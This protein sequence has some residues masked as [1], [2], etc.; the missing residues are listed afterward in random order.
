MFKQQFR[1]SRRYAKA[2]LLLSQ[3]HEMVERSYADM[4]L[5]FQVFNQ[6]K[7]LQVIMRSPIIRIGKKQR[8]LQ[9][10]FDGKI[11]PLTFNYL[12]IIIRKQRAALIMSIAR[13]FLVVYKEAMGIELV[14][15]TTAVAMTAELRKKALDVAHKLTSLQIEF[16]EFVDARIIGGFIL[17]IGDRQYDAS[18]RNKLVLMKKHLDIHSYS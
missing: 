8:V 15:V 2:L 9:R 13:A 3:E 7:D 17:T 10:L 14:K 18:I 12:S 5:I 6:S 1:V 16:E 11:Q 4:K